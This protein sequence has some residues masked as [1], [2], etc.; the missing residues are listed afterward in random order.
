[1]PR[2]YGLMIVKNEA[3]IVGQ[4]L[5][6]ALAHCDKIIVM[7]NMSTDGTWELVQDLAARHPGR[8]VAHCRLDRPF[9]DCLRA[10][11]YNA[12]HHELSRNDW[13]LRLDADEFLNELPGPLL[14]RAAKEGAD[15][16]RA[17]QMEF[18]LTEHDVTAIEKGEAADTT[19]TTI[20]DHDLGPR[21]R[22]PRKRW[23]SVT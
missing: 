10:I 11:A 12:F 6:H 17:N 20:S 21:G 2:I 23:A 7:D 1:M 18:A 15:F 14:E 8:I 5:V 16:I 9:H 3:D 4:C 13:W 22:Q 19:G